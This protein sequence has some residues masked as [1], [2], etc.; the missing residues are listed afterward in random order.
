MD[1]QPINTIRHVNCSLLQTKQTRCPTCVKYR[2]NLNAITRKRTYSDRQASNS[3]FTNHRYMNKEQMVSKIGLLSKRIKEQSR[4]IQNIKKMVED[5]QR[6]TVLGE[7]TH[8]DLLHIMQ[9]HHKHICESYPEES[10][11]R[12]FW[13]DQFNA[14]SQKSHTQFRWHPTMIKW[15]IFLRH[16]SSKAYE[17][18]RKSKCI[19]LPSQ[20]TL[21]DYTHAFQS[22]LGFSATLDRQ[23]M[24]DSGIS[25]LESF[26][27]HICLLGDEMYIKEGLIYN[28]HSGDLV[29]YCDLGEINNHLLRLEHEYQTVQVGKSQLASTMMVLMVRSLFTNFTFPYACFATSTLTGEQLV[30]IFY[31][32]IMRTERCGFRVS[33]ITLDGNS[34]NRKFFKL[35]GNNTDA[36]ITHK[37]LNPLSFNSREV[38]LFSDPP[39]LI[40]TARNCLASTK[41]NMEVLIYSNL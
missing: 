34:V 16:K 6:T 33:C 11:Q 7:T 22:S 20:R 39:H 12:I 27:K 9:E 19:Y 41:R 17:L 18:L 32:A 36:H 14:A 23:L 13:M 40:K 38:Y 10:F 28:K 26:Q 35:I 30:P 31:E 4:N 29:G 1:N 25:K 15:C 37:F 2:R 8:N 5:D 3:S 24:N 21:R